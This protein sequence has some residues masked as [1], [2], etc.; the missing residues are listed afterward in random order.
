MNNPHWEPQATHLPLQN[1]VPE[2]N[3]LPDNIHFTKALTKVISTPIDYCFK[4]YVYIDDTSTVA[5][6][7]P[8]ILARDRL[9]V[10]L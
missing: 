9:A 2:D 10:P 7:N 6:D 8:V 5:L 4:V 1:E 3:P